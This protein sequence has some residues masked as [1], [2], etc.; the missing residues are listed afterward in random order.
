M[1][2]WGRWQP[3]YLL[4]WGNG[5]HAKVLADA[6]HRTC[7]MCFTDPELREVRDLEDRLSVPPQPILGF[8]D[9]KMRLSKAELME[10]H[11]RSCPAILVH[12]RGL[13]SN[14]SE[15]DFGTF[16][17]AGAVVMVAVVGKHCIV[18]HNA[19][20]DHDCRLDDHCIVC[21]GAN[22]GGGVQLGR[23]VLIGM[24]AVVLP[25]VIIGEGATVGAGA[26]VTK[27]VPPL[28]VVVGNPARI[29]R[30]ATWETLPC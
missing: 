1:K 10:I 22:L 20:V 28:A 17:A 18:N 9:R 29:I 21:P 27:D 11:F 24:G 5:G 30:Y 4:V 7:S 12:E 19:T 26:V 13:V 2:D 14:Y 16:V 15:L 23:A 6:M 3:R 8:G 25:K